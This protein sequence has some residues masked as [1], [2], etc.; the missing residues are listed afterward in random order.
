MTGMTDFEVYKRNRAPAV[1][2][3][4]ITV[5]Q[6][7]QLSINDAAY[8]LL[9]SPK[10]I[11]LMYSRADRI[12]GLRPIDAS[13]PHAYV[14]RTRGEKYR[15]HGPYV[16]S[17][18]AFFNYFGITVKETTRYAATE[19]N[20]IVTIDLKDHDGLVA[21]G[22]SETTKQEGSRPRRTVRRGGGVQNDL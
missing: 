18:A 5:T 12:V 11:E 3:P 10:A 20:G 13:E 6:R 7:L 8:A 16:V 14:L 19:Q 15:G 21:D 2:T 17:G 9:G 4:A 1:N 22:E